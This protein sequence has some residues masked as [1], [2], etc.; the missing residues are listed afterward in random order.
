[1]NPFYIIVISGD[2][3]DVTQHFCHSGIEFLSLIGQKV[4]INLLQ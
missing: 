2:L 1:M 3:A 4:L